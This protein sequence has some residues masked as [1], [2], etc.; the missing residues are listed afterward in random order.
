[1]TL[2]TRG[3][4]FSIFFVFRARL[5]SKGPPGTP[6]LMI[7][8]PKMDPQSSQNG[9]QGTPRPKT[10][11]AFLIEFLL[12]LG[13]VWL[14]KCF[15]NCCESDQKTYRKIEWKIIEKLI[16]NDPQKGPTHFVM[17][18]VSKS[19]KE[20]NKNPTKTSFDFWNECFISKDPWNSMCYG[21]RSILVSFWCFRFQTQFQNRSMFKNT[22]GSWRVIPK[23]I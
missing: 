16:K 4:P 20:L 3:T 8:A 14:P 23:R 6:K 21:F 18:R 7:L 22:F 17:A 5:G 19:T 9:V 12:I 1:M 11:I 13:S 15:L 10:S 2:L